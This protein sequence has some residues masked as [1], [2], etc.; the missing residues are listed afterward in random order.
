MSQWLK[1]CIVFP[2]AQVWFPTLTSVSR[3][4]QPPLTAAPRNV[5]PLNSGPHVHGP[6]PEH[7][8]TQN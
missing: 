5:I 3:S 8:H 7:I 2:E 6:T 4:S 1:A